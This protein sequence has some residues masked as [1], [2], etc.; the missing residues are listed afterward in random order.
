MTQENKPEIWLSIN[1]G[2]ALPENDL[3][4]IA[5]VKTHLLTDKQIKAECMPGPLKP[6]P[7]LEKKIIM[8]LEAGAI[9][10][11]K[12]TGGERGS[13][14]VPECVWLKHCQTQPHF[15]DSLPILFDIEGDGGMMFSGAFKD[16]PE[17]CRGF[18]DALRFLE[19]AV[20]ARRK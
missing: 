1:V 10:L 15:S 5:T 11:D 19:T 13:S 14:V 7:Q 12:L 4:V 8:S 17:L 20:K 16:N 18:A 3:D 9:A 2:G 6:N